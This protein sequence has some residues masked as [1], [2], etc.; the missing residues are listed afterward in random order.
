MKKICFDDRFS[1]TDMVK[2]GSKTMLRRF[3]AEYDKPKYA[4]GETIAIAEAYRNIPALQERKGDPDLMNAGW[5]SKMF[6]RADLMPCR[7]CITGLRSERLRDISEE[8]CLREGVYRLGDGFSFSDSQRRVGVK[9]VFA[10]AQE[11]FGEMISQMF[12]YEVWRGNPV[13]KVYE[14]ERV[15]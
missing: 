3:D 6:I 14:F 10:T 9:K 1:H 7:I 5:N 13:V 11:A 4:V 2:D 15:Q 12:G 8:D